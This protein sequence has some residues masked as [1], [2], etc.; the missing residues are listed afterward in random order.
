MRRLL[1][2]FFLGSI[3]GCVTE[4]SYVDA[5]GKAMTVTANPAAAAVTRLDLGLQYL[6]QGNAE[7]AKFNLDKA[8]NLDGANPDVHLGFAHFYQVVGDDRAAEASYH[9]VLQLQPTN[10][11]AMN[12]YGAFL[13]GRQRYAEADTWFKRALGQP[14]YN[15]M[16]ATYENAAVC[17]QAGE[18]L[19]RAITYYRLGLGYTPKEPKFLFALTE[20]GLAVADLTLAQTYLAQHAAVMG[21]NAATLWLRL[22]VAD[23]LHQPADREQYG[24]DLVRYFPNSPFARRYITHDY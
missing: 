11:D 18:H 2:G 13:C 12:N 15:K 1:I 4:T 14:N 9:K 17:A 8:L 19:D 16:A 6:Q 20:L 10:G 23:A 7:Q 3:A 22:Q 5:N 21:E 24:T